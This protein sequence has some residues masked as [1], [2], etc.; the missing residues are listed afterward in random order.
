MNEQ[1]VV[2]SAV[3]KHYFLTSS[4]A[5]L[6]KLL[7][8]THVDEPASEIINQCIMRTCEQFVEEEEDHIIYLPKKKANLRKE[9]GG[10]IKA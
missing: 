1:T 10:I 2:H 6:F 7:L 3:K 9:I 8:H 4:A 5:K